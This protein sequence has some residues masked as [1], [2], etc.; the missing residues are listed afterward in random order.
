MPTNTGM[1]LVAGFDDMPQD[2]NGVTASAQ[3]LIKMGLP[4]RLDPDKITLAVNDLRAILSSF[5]S[6]PDEHLNLQNAI[7][8]Q[9]FREAREIAKRVGITE[10]DLLANGGQLWGVVVVIAI[11]AAVL[12]EHD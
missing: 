11:A 8:R 12:L 5:E 9:D 4:D 7:L 10:K 3:R 2:T 6:Y 1:K